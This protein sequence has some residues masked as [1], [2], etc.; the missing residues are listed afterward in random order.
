M[1]HEERRLN[2]ALLLIDIQKDY[3]PDGRMELDGALEAAKIASEVLRLF[4]LSKMHIYHVHHVSTGSTASFFIP[5]TDGILPH[6]L[7]TPEEGEEI[8]IKHNP[9]SFLG[10]DLLE[11]LKSNNIKNIVIVGMMTHM[12]VD[13]TTRAAHDLGFLCTVIYEG[14]ATKSISFDDKHV[15]SKDVQNAF[16]AS[17]NGTYAHV[18][19]F[20]EFLLKMDD[21]L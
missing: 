14:C 3:F 19:R 6:P 15:S 5:G 7:V 11:K 18:L 12:C 1:A 21:L 8:I 4:R 10:T 2:T 13:A 16:M 9:N 20:S 17:L